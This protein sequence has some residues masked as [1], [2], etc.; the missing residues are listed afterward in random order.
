MKR[1][2]PYDLFLLVTC[3]VGGLLAH[4]FHFGII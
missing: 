4:L 1:L 3:G 2:T